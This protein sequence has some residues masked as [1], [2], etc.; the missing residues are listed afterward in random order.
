MEDRPAAGNAGAAVLQ[1]DKS[2]PS[3]S[4][5]AGNEVVAI[6]LSVENKQTLDDFLETVQQG[7]KSQRALELT[8]AVSM[9]AR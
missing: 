3:K 7:E 8:E 1:K 4:S 9:P 2:I 6:R 5:T